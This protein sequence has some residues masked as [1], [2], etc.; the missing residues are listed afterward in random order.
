[1]IK[2]LSWL[3]SVFLFFV[4]FWFAVSV[5]LGKRTLWGHLRAIFATQ[6]ARDL[7]EGT[8]EQAKRVAERVREEL[9][10]DAGPHRGHHE[11]NGELVKAEKKLD[12]SESKPE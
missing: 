11:A 12:K 6:E 4:V 9:H 7:A 10:P 3:F 8:K 2:L 1:M 5:P